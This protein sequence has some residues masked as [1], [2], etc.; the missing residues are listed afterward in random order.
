MDDSFYLAWL[1]AKETLYSISRRPNKI[2]C[3]RALPRFIRK[4]DD[5]ENVIDV[6]CSTY[7]IKQYANN[8]YFK[9]KYYYCLEKSKYKKLIAEQELKDFDNVKIVQG[10]ILN[11]NEELFFEFDFLISTHLLTLLNPKERETALQNMLRLVKP[12][13]YLLIQCKIT[14]YQKN[15]KLFNRCYVLDKKY[16]RRYLCKKFE[17]RTKKEAG[18]LMRVASLIVSYFDW[19][20]RPSNCLILI[21]KGL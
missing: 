3:Y 18:V 19:F 4:V 12:K 1:D 21:K 17:E 16:Y 5:F 20:G 13:G 7:A 6:G 10:D 2:I 14:D 15:K 9:E 11:I 8:F